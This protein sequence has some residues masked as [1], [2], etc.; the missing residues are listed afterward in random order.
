MAL[1]GPLPSAVNTPPVVADPH[2]DRRLGGEVAVGQLVGDHPHA[3]DAEEVLLPPGGPAHQQLE[4]GVGGLEVVALVLEALEVVDHLVTAGPSIARPSS[5]AFIV[6]V[7]RPAISLTT[8]RV[9]L[10][11]SSGSTCS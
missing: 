2:L 4:R 7:A 6:I 1:T 5:S 8:K 3:L 11:T 9:P 10:P